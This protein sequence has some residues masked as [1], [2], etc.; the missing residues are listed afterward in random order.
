MTDISAKTVSSAAGFWR[1]NGYGG[2]ADLLL[3]LRSAIDAAE[4]R[5]RERCAQCHHQPFGQGGRE[6]TLRERLADWLSGGQLTQVKEQDHAAWLEAWGVATEY[7]QALE[8]IAEMET[9]AANAT[10]RRMAA[11][12]REA[13][14]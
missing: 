9:G 10:V 2:L 6:M 4:A 12:A 8:E 1:D 13:L 11:R 14:Q 7:M 3:A 5:E